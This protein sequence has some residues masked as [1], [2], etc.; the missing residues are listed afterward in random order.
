MQVISHLI[1]KVFFF[2][3]ALTVHSG[4]QQQLES[5][6]LCY[7]QLL[8]SSYVPFHGRRKRN[9]IHTG[10]VHGAEPFNINQP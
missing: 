9:N 10:R 2:A 1:E 3:S 5:F 8:C 4:F 6:R 7:C